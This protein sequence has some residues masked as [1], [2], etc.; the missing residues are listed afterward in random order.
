MALTNWSNEP[1]I[2]SLKIDLSN[3]STSHSVQVTKINAWL[4]KLEA[5]PL[6]ENQIKKN[7]K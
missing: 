4:E 7:R 3:S 6:Y 1:T 5:K 2:Q